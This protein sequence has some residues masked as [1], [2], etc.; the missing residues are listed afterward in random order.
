MDKYEF[1]S[2]AWIKMAREVILQALQGADI[3]NVTFSLSEEFTNPPE[4][5]RR[6]DAATI[7]FTVRLDNGHAEVAAEPREDAEFRVISDYADALV[8][9]R[10]PELAAADPQLIVERLTQGRLKIIGN[11]AGVPAAL[12][13][14]DVHRLLAPHTA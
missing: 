10:D 5:L 3:S 2:D 4:H 14:L 12:Q 9:A 1:M 7:G 8:L 11:P 13:N 6:P